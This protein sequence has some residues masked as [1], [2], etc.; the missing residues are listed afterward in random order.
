VWVLTAMPRILVADDHAVMRRGI[1]S[2]LEAESW[3]VCCEAATGKQAVEMAIKQKPDVAVVDLSMP[4]LNGF[5]AARHIVEKAPETQVLIFT[6]HEGEV[7]MHEVLACGARGCVLKTEME[8]HLVAAVRALLQHSIYFSS[9][10]SRNSK[11]VADHY[12]NGK[13]TDK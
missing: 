10:A 3:E 9:G 5:D 11:D 12:Q 8:E 4:E 2:L 6:M 1:R 13:G 7:L